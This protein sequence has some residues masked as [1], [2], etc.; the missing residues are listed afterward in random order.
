MDAT[1]GENATI[2]FF[3][4]TCGEILPG[5]ANNGIACSSCVTGISIPTSNPEN[6]ANLLPP[7]EETFKFFCAHC[8]QKFSSPVGFVGQQFNCPICSTEN[9]VPAPHSAAL[10]RKNPPV[11]S[12]SHL[13]PGGD[14]PLPKFELEP[15]ATSPESGHPE[16]LLLLDEGPTTST[17]IGRANMNQ[18]DSTMNPVPGNTD[19]LPSQK[20]DRCHKM[21]RAK[22]PEEAE[23][24]PIRITHPING[25]NRTI[26]PRRR[27]EKEPNELI[28]IRLGEEATALPAPKVKQPN[29]IAGKVSDFLAGSGLEGDSI[30]QFFGDEIEIDKIF[31][32]TKTQV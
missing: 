3:C 15:S 14:A 26:L 16:Q 29:F 31:P 24:E 5:L 19:Q 12:S 28:S 4:A 9:I 21:P 27:A 23:T 32:V 17:A 1:N 7:G 8:E 18:D 22:E 11:I 10:P 13:D 6:S 20:Q 2:N 30:N 25:E